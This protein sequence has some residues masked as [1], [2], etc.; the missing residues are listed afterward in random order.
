MFDYKEKYSYKAF[1]IITQLHSFIE[2]VPIRFSESE[3]MSQMLWEM[4]VHVH[5]R[6][7][8]CNALL[9]IFV[10]VLSGLSFKNY[11]LP[12]GRLTMQPSQATKWC[13]SRVVHGP[14]LRIQIELVL[15]QIRQYP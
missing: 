1:E 4:H 13:G 9:Q 2:S 11:I 3:L 7:S 10:F 12:L 8:L 6:T 14:H 5:L 15:G